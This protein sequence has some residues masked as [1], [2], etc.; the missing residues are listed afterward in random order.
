LIDGW[1]RKPVQVWG[2]V[3]SAV[4]LVIFAWM[5]ASPGGSALAAY[6]VYGLFNVTQTGP[7]LVSGAG[8]YGVELAPTRIRSVAQSV[9]VV[10]GRIGATISGFAFPVMADPKHLGLIGSMY[11]LAG[12]SLVG[13]VLSQLLVP[14]TSTRSLEEINQEAPPAASVPAGG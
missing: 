5:R 14:E 4:V 2:F 8:V 7:G 1:G 3:A 12:I 13:G 11:V 6:V 10:G 9:T